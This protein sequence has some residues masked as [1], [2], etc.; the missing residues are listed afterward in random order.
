MLGV[1]DT[2]LNERAEA[3]PETRETEDGSN[4]IRQMFG[5]EPDAQQRRVLE[6]NAMR[7]TLNCTRQ[8]GK[9]TITA[10]KAVLQAWG[11][12]DSLT[13]VVSPSAR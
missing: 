3:R 2:G 4:R 6:S 13:L 12:K 7:G 9:S 11:D 1:W 8:W 10:A 5:F